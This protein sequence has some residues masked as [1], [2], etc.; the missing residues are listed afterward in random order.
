MREAIQTWA[1][2]LPQPLAVILVAMLPIFELRGAIPFARGIFGMG[3]VAALWWSVVGNLIPIPF[4]LQ[5]LGPVTSWAERHWSGLHR[6]LDRRYSRTRS[7]H[8]TRFERLRDLALVTFVAIPLPLTGAWSG[9]LAAF[10][11]GIEKRRAFV[12][13]AVGVVIAGLVVS[14]VWEA[15]SRLAG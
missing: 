2:Q 13:I 5:L 12:L 10:V 15:G 4:I 7:R 14:L 3:P 9:A 8:T 11:F 1:A 6:L